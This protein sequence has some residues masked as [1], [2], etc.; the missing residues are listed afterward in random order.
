MPRSRSAMIA[1]TLLASAL[2][3][4]SVAHAAGPPS[5]RTALPLTFEANRGH[6]PPEVDFSARGDGYKLWLT[7]SEAVLAVRGATAPV[8]VRMGVA[9]VAATASARGDQRLPGVVNRVSGNDRR[10]WTSAP[11]FGAVRYQG[12]YPGIDLVYYGNQRQLEYDFVVAPG[13]DPGQIALAFTGARPRLEADGSLV[14]AHAEGELRFAAPVLYQRFLGVRLPVAGAFTVDGD[15]VGFTVGAYDRHRALVIDPIL[16]YSSFVGGTDNDRG[17]AITVDNQGNAYAC[18]YAYSLTYPTVVPAQAA[19]AGT[20]DV[21]VSKLNAAGTALLYSTYLGGTAY[22]DCTGIALAAND[23]V[24]ITGRTNSTDFPVTA[25][26]YDTVHNGNGD[27]F[28]AR[29]DA[30]TGTVNWSTFIG[31]SSNDEPQD[32]AIDSQ[33][34]PVIVGKTQSSNHPT[35]AGAYDT[36]FNGGSWDAFVSRLS[37]N[38][39]SLSY[40]TYLGSSGYDYGNGIAMAG[41]E[42]YVTGY[43]SNGAFPTTAG[44]YDTTFNGGTG[45]VF[46]T[47]L[48]AGG[49]ALL[50]STFVGGSGTDSGEDLAIG[51]GGHVYVGGWTSSTNYPTTVGAAD[52][53]ANGGSDAMVTKLNG[54]LASLTYSTYAGGASNDYGRGIAVNSGGG[55]MLV[56]ETSSSGFPVVSATQAVYGG[57]IVDVFVLRV[58]PTGSGFN[59]STFLGGT[60]SEYG[61]AVA[62]DSIGDAYVTG[63]A[64]DNAFPTVVGSYDVSHNGSA[65]LFVTKFAM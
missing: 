60:G 27:G 4:T 64:Y 36:T 61:S 54:T 29:I 17:D 12:V 45:D 43:T 47:R 56:G 58:H 57:G 30:L 28:V 5:T 48:N 11:T 16:T 49:T 1:S 39:A 34:R 42:A 63:V 3:L 55:A 22:E 35:S 20:Q 59:F 9:G 23:D 10:Q 15:R 46:V 51:S 13:A 24:F 33:G 18:G 32:L 62:V 53:T 50:A 26:A 52:V 2:G 21:V 19:N 40:S 41:D 38:G 65:D 8:I 44:A 25:G 31:G 14:L 37:A 6:E 7:R